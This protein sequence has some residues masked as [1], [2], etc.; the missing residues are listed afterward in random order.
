MQPLYFLHI[1]KTA[2]T[3]LCAWLR[4]H[5]DPARVCA[6]VS[7]ARLVEAPELLESC[8]LVCGHHGMYLP[9]LADRGWR[10]VT[11]VR[12]PLSRSVSHY[13]DICAR[14]DHPL[15]A[16]AAADTFES[17]VCSEAGDAELRNLQ[18]R[19]LALDDV[20]RDYFGHERARRRDAGALREKYSCPSLLERARANAA[21]MAVVGLSEQAQQASVSIASLLGWDAPGPLP[22][23]NA[24][25]APFDSSALTSAAV[26]RVRELTR[27]DQSLY[28][29]VLAGGGR[30]ATASPPTHIVS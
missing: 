4:K 2:G 7:L 11:L 3:S 25:R 27:L 20:E 5:F 10:I 17:F 14:S 15:H 29:G 21:E 26:A 13:R 12:D 28:E 30:A 18:C 23:L 9:R 6:Q 1:P 24:A 8:D 19:F 22:R 16:T